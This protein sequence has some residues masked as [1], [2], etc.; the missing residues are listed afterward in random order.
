MKQR[1]A[2]FDIMKGVAIILM[3]VGHWPFVP[4]WGI[5]WIFSFHMP[6]FFILAGYFHKVTSDY[7][8][9]AVKSAKRLLIPY[10]LCAA[11]VLVYEIMS[12]WQNHNLQIFTDHL[13]AVFY[14]S[15][16]HHSSLYGANFPNVGPTWFLFALFWCK[17]AGNFFL[18]KKTNY[19][20]IIVVALLATALDYYLI[21]LPLAILPGLSALTFFLI[22]YLVKQYGLPEWL[23]IVCVISWPFAAEFAK[24]FMGTCT[25]RIYPLAISG[26]CGG[27]LVVYYLSRGMECVKWLSGPMSWVGKNSLTI[28]I[29]HVIWSNCHL[30]GKLVPTE[31]WYVLAVA[32]IAFVIIS[33]FICAIIPV[34]KKIFQMS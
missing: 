2:A 34:S 19:L 23:A 11:I 9:L 25:Y 18:D 28:L 31:K 20:L 24:V 26:A 3:I 10:F 8:T 33:T 29:F 6:L 22:G 27:T 21:H 13:W 14:A 1:V 5:R 15:G 32:E 4:E 30:A 16:A 7:R 17:L 12:A